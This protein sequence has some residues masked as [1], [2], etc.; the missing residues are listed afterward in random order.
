MAH[1]TVTQDN[2]S[3]LCEAWL[4]ARDQENEAQKRRRELEMKIRALV[5]ASRDIEGTYAV[6]VGPY[7]IKV[8]SRA[9]REVNTDMVFQI[10][11]ENGLTK[12]LPALFFWSAEINKEAWRR[13]DERITGLLERALTLKFKQHSFNISKAQEA[14]EELSAAQAT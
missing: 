9:E 1:Y 11:Y 13:A 5:G 14:Q 3:E 6:V 8:V 7:T 10:A 4:E 12:H 2:L